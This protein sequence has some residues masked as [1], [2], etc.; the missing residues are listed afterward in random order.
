[1]IKTSVKYTEK[2]F[3]NGFL[4]VID[5]KATVLFFKKDLGQHILA[6]SKSGKSTDEYKI[7]KTKI[8]K[9]L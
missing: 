6:R 1:M 8:I 4:T 2:S 9:I 7:L 3:P 5:G